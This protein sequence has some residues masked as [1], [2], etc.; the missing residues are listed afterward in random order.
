MHPLAAAW[1]ADRDFQRRVEGLP[2]NADVPIFVAW[3][4][5]IVAL[6]GVLA[7]YVPW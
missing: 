4:F 5:A 2:M 6:V 1:P 3:A 7:F